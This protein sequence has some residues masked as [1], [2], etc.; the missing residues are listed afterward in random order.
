MET[1]QTL[2]KTPL[3]TMADGR[4]L[5]VE[6]HVV[7]FA[8]GTII[9]DW[10]WLITPDYVNVFPVMDDG[11]VLCF[12]QAKYAVSGLSLSIPGGYLEPGEA[13]LATVQRELL[14][15]TGCVA[16]DWVAL[17]SY[18]V[19]G[20]RGCGR[21][22]LFLA[23]GVRQ[24]QPSHADDLE[25]QATVLLTLAEVRAALLAGEFRVLP[26]STC[27]ALALLHLAEGA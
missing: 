5:R 11:R 8:D 23:T 7:Q 13:P 6:Q 19:D 15:E 3:L 26:W 2:H 14:E 12:R 18:A 27:V 21:A 4:F 17:G 10:P 16:A 20:N 25:E 22:H 24:V 1:I 9:E